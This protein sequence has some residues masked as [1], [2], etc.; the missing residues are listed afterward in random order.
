MFITLKSINRNEFERVKG[1]FFLRDVQV[2]LFIDRLIHHLF[3]I[4]QK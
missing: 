3:L 4:F 1:N 2:Y